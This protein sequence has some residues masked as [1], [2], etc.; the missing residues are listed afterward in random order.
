MLY[1]VLK[2]FISAIV[3]V[4][5]S[6]IAKRSTGFAALVASLPLTSLPLTS[7]LAFIWLHLEGTAPLQIAD[8]SKQIFWLV[9]PSLLLF[10]LLPILLKQG[11]GFWLSLGLSAAATMGC[12]FAFF[13]ILRR[14]EAG[15]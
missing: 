5:I 10:L 2:V 8:L 13:F 12:Y 14:I 11:V 3:I 1:Y 15:L 6:E 7:L 9:L 4:A